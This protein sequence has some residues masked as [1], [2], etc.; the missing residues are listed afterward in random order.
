MTIF[1]LFCI[2]LCLFAWTNLSYI[3]AIQSASAP[4]RSHVHPS[5]R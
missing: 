1:L 4:A 5:P 2:L 3:R